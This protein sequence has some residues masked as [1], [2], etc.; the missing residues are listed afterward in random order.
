MILAL[1]WAAKFTAGMVLDHGSIQRQFDSWDKAPF[2]FCVEVASVAR[3]FDVDLVLV[4]D[5]PY[6]INQQSQIKAVLRMQGI[7]MRELNVVDKLDV[8]RFLTP[9]T[10][11]RYFEGVF[12]CGK[13]GAR[14]A[15]D[16]LGYTAPDLLAIHADEIPAKGPERTKMRA[17][18]KKAMTDYDD[19]FL[20]GTW[21]SE[22]SLSEVMDKTQ[23]PMI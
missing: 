6:G 7:L 19:S 21:G 3:E 17:Q 10:W 11:Q 2:A 20:I 5:L 22:L 4:E 13:E 16:R 1:D 15:A 12:R 14:A 8:T 18:L 23:P 9:S